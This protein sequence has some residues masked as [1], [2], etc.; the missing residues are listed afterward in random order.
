MVMFMGSYLCLLWTVRSAYADGGYWRLY[1]WF[2]VCIFFLD[3]VQ[4]DLYKRGD[5]SGSV[6]GRCHC[7]YMYWY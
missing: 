3:A 1:T 6:I 2:V 5:R 4:F 7:S